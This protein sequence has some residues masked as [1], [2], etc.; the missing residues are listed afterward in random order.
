MFFKELRKELF[1]VFLKQIADILSLYKLSRSL[2]QRECCNN[3]YALEL[4]A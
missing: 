2:E 1:N 4:H 3:Q